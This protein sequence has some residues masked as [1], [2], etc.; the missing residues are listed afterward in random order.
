MIK[1]I[2]VVAAVG[3]AGVAAGVIGIDMFY[4]EEMTVA[5]RALGVASL[6]TLLCVLLTFPAFK[7]LFL[8]NKLLSLL[9]APSLVS[10]FSHYIVKF[11]TGSE[12]A[13]HCVS[14]VLKEGM[15]II[16]GLR[17]S[18]GWMIVQILLC[19]WGLH[20]VV[21]D[22]LRWEEYKAERAAKY[23]Q[24]KEAFAV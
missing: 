22:T 5:L 10:V 8:T 16:Q 1:F 17:M 19:V 12:R 20:S 14:G 2:K 15:G 9:L 3:F 13:A 23:A 21:R 4:S 6:V 11:A 24:Y 7:A 18:I